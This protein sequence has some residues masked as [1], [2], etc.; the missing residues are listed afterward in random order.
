MTPSQFRAIRLRHGLTQS[1]LMPLIGIAQQHTISRYENG[2][3]PVPN[4]MA[5]LMHRLDVAGL[6][7]Y[8]EDMFG[9]EV[10]K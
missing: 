4:A 5:L 1:Q 8:K 7:K 3:A 10:V 2:K 6:E 9:D